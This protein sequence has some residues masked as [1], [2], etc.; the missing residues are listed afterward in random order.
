MK[1]QDGNTAAQT[2]FQQAIMS[3]VR[4]IART[5][6]PDISFSDCQSPVKDNPYSASVQP[7]RT[8]SDLAITRGQADAFALRLA[9]HD[10]DLHRA[11]RPQGD[12]AATVFDKLEQCR[13]EAIGAQRMDGV[14]LNLSA[15]L[16][17]AC[18]QSFISQE[19]DREEEIDRAII[20]MV[21]ETIAA[22]TLPD[23]ARQLIEP[24]RSWI[25]EKISRQLR[26]LIDRRDD[27]R[28][29]A[30][31]LNDL[32]IQLHIADKSASETEQNQ[33]DT[34]DQ[35]QL[36]D[37]T[38][39]QQSMEKADET[40]SRDEMEEEPDKG[41]PDNR[42][43]V[44]TDASKA[45]KDQEAQ[46]GHDNITVK[47]HGGDTGALQ[48]KIYS[49]A[50]DENIHAQDLCQDGEL[51]RLRIFFDKQHSHLKSTVTRLAN[52]LQRR[53]MA[54]Q[55]RAWDFDLEE[56][57][58]D[59]SRIARIITDPMHPLSFKCERTASFRDTVVTLLLDN[60]GSMRGRPIMMTA[61]CADILA[62]TLERCSVK[63]EILGFTTRSWKG[64]QARK[65]WIAEGSPA[66][67]GRLNELRH[68]IYKSADTPWRHA[69]RNIGL[70]MREGLLK[71]NI[72]GEA[73]TWA[74]QRL[75]NRPEQRKI[76]LMIS[77][78]APIDDSTLSVNED[79]Y[80]ERHLR[81]TI[82]E[83]ES[84]SPVQLIAIGIGHDVTR[85]YRHAITISH[86]EELGEALTEK[87]D[88]LFETKAKPANRAR[89][90]QWIQTPQAIFSPREPEPDA[91]SGAKRS[92]TP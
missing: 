5:P 22:S 19:H 14:A 6:S 75:L 70:M 33:E 48:Y 50:F 9:Y 61:A 4:A 73:L 7:L 26:D 8:Q 31:I 32:I 15:M 87:L 25:N 81:R 42:E 71:E 11:L 29:F 92:T 83:I 21:R 64:G 3:T 49:T 37:E 46:G 78:G 30:Q 82:E 44:E 86:I 56:G 35:D 43:T 55:N 57:L 65:K 27:Q 62:R 40:T 88:E 91:S 2:P 58:L 20:L 52:R 41:E 39:H 18:S 90:P 68:I 12:R 24:W 38:N 36:E 54:Q 67:P 1:R 60:S 89:R 53:L 84:K 66:N 10:P 13:V 45:G 76:L 17:Q 72:D 74:H 69:K 16:S 85:Y 80:L 79:D 23:F 51:E 77:D 63:T 59:T 34:E 28:A 47:R